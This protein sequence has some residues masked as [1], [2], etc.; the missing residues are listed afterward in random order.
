MVIRFFDSYY[1]SRII[2]LALLLSALFSGLMYFAEAF[3]FSLWQWQKLGQLLE[4]GEYMYGDVWDNTAPLYAWFAYVMEVLFGGNRVAYG[5]AGVLLVFIQAILFSYINNTHRIVSRGTYIFSLFYVLFFLGNHHMFYISPQLVG[6]TFVLLAFNQLLKCS[7]AGNV[8]LSAMFNIGL[9]IGMASLFYFGYMFFM[10]LLVIGLI[11]F[12]SPRAVHVLNIVLGI[13][14]PLMLVG[15]YYFYV[16]DLWWFIKY[17]IFRSFGYSD[18]SSVNW[19]WFIFPA[20]FLGLWLLISVVGHLAERKTSNFQ[21]KVRSF[22]LAWLVFTLLVMVFIF[23][24]LPYYDWV[25]IAPPVTYFISMFFL[26]QK[27][28]LFREVLF[29]ILIAGMVGGGAYLGPRVFN[30]R[31]QG[32]EPGPS[33]RF[34]SADSVDVPVNRRITNNELQKLSQKELVHVYRMLESQ[35]PALIHDDEDFT[36]REIYNQ[37]PV[38]R[39]RYRKESLRWY[40]RKK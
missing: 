24:R 11:S 31:E 3:P 15:L 32:T 14:F 18:G 39:Q 8:T 26:Q 5:V 2:Y 16:G 10:L 4:Q 29:F 33:V 6:M 13:M 20:G 34:L 40:A 37:S 25:L 28:S 38:I 17:Y 7:Q 9:L 30:P 1:P 22:Y 23:R 12:M 35:K 19:Q 27:N 21:S 36:F